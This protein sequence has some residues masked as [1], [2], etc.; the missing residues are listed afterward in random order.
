[1]AVHADPIPLLLGANLTP[2]ECESFPNRA[3]HT[4]SGWWRVRIPILT[5]N[6][7]EF[8]TSFA[9]ESPLNSL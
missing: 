5:L 9:D 3:A 1:M 2:P 7:R 8:S 4:P 6:L